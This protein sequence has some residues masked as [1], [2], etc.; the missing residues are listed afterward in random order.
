MLAGLRVIE[1][2][3]DHAAYA[4]LLLSGL[5][6]DVVVVE[7]PG[8][9][10]SRT[11]GPFLDDRAD[12]E[13]SLYWWHYNVGK[14]S[15]VIDLEREADVFRR[16]VATADVVLEGEAPGRLAALGIDHDD[17]RREWPELVWCSL[18][19]YG[20]AT[21]RAHEEAVDLTILAEGGPVWMCGYDDH[22][23]PPVRGGGNQGYQTGCVW[24]V[25][26]ILTAVLYLAAGGAGQHIDVSLFAAAN[27]TCEAGTYEWLVARETVQRQTCRHA[28]VV[29]SLPDLV[30]GTDGRLIK[31]GLP[32]RTGDQYRQLLAWL[33]ELG[34]REECPD[35]AV[36]E[37]GTE[38]E[39]TDFRSVGDDPLVTEI[40]TSARGALNFLASKLTGYE[41]FSGAQRHGIAVGIVYAPEEVMEDAHFRAR[42]FPTEVFHDDLDRTVTYPG[43]PFTS[44]VAPW[45]LSRRPPHVGEHDAE[46]LG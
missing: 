28:T 23:L 30:S 29:P 3:S 4:G 37:L 2:A 24:A 21:S 39:E 14:R 16:L 46:I 15:V 8:G 1:L 36:I 6:A 35:V 18:T 44:Q 33:D 13:G 9:H 45:Q 31:T 43:G 34:L 25:N 10:R 32:P 20:R 27:I 42:R 22:S 40:L 26:A 12:V 5:G 19:P 11:F 7:P 41:F 17:L 38:R